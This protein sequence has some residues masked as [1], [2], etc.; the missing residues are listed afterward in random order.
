MY[1]CQKNTIMK[2]SAALFKT[3]WAKVIENLNNVGPTAWD[4]R[5]GQIIEENTFEAYFPFKK[6][7]NVKEFAITKLFP[8]DPL[9][10]KNGIVKRLGS[11]ETKA[12]PYKNKRMNRYV[13][14]QFKRLNESRH[15][16]EKF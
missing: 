10:L 7:P 6:L 13:Y 14:Y 1:N 12:E 8:L 3:L 4:S 2:N 11:A 9:L 5:L 15:Q 16:P